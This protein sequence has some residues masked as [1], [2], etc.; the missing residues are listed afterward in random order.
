MKQNLMSVARKFKIL[1]LAEYGRF[2]ISLLK[3]RLDNQKFLSKQPS[4]VP[5]PCWLA[6]D[7]YG[8]T[9]W[10]SYDESGLEHA[11][12][13]SELILKYN[14]SPSL[15]V[16]DWGCGPGRLIRH[17]PRLLANRY[18][19]IYGT[20]YNTKTISWCRSVLK[21]IIFEQNQLVPPLVF[22]SNFFNAIY[23]LSVLTHLSEATHFAWI[24]ELNRI[25]KPGGILI[26]TTHGDAYRDK[27]L[28]KEKID[29]DSHNLV[30]RHGVQEGKRCYTAF[31][32]PQFIKEKLFKSW[33]ILEH[34]PNSLSRKIAQDIWVV[35]K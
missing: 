21:D 16:L 25:L 34:I 17:M 18:P 14:P 15:H 2:L 9:S 29:Y 11:I 30:I 27:L 20:D 6:Y 13:F 4:F 8:H 12:F 26:I 3:S 23:G 10:R 35:Q 1:F 32:P 28:S 7:A 22:Q 19:K 31:H 33:K 24:D 5:P